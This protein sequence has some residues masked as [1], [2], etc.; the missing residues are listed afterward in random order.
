MVSPQDSI[1]APFFS[2]LS[3]HLRFFTPVVAKNSFYSNPWRSF[4]AS[5]AF[6]LQ[7]LGPFCLHIYSQS[8]CDILISFSPFSEFSLFLFI[9]RPSPYHSPFHFFRMTPYDI[10]PPNLKDPSPYLLSQNL[11]PFSFFMINLYLF[12]NPF[13]SVKILPLQACPCRTVSFTHPF[14]LP[15]CLLNVSLPFPDSTPKHY[16]DVFLI[17]LFPLIETGRLS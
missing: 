8:P 3:T 14:P 11:P 5:L 6:H 13:P 15:I 17:L 1:K 4:Y 10:I 12:S 16:Y 7:F 2:L 9:V